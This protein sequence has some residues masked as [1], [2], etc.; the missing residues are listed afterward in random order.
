MA[1]TP[2]IKVCVIHPETELCQ[3]CFRTLAEIA[4]WGS[5]SDAEHDNVLSQIKQ[6]KAAHQPAP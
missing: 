2:C 1:N 5:L 4:R 3:G 6:R